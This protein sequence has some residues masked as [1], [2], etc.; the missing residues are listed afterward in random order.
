MQIFI[1]HT[2]PRVS[3][4]SACQGGRQSDVMVHRVLKLFLLC[5]IFAFF[6]SHSFF[7]FIFFLLFLRL[8]LKELL[9]AIHSQNQMTSC[10][11]LLWTAQNVVLY[12]FTFKLTL[13]YKKNIQGAA[14]FQTPLLFIDSPGILS[15]L[16]R[17]DK[18]QMVVI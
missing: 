16:C 9:S 18:C 6:V 4:R 1:Y 14:C 8:L 17:K 5:F 2:A 3:V 15:S 7:L 10:P 13:M 11:F 12:L